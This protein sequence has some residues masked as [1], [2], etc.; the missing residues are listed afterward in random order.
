MDIQFPEIVLIVRKCTGKDGLNTTW[1]CPSALLK[2]ICCHG[3]KVGYL[4]YQ[5]TPNDH[6]SSAPLYGRM[7]DANPTYIFSESLII[8]D[9]DG[10]FTN[11]KKI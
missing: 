8:V 9:S 1:K 4:R 3:Y 6:H 11:V 10:L 5:C 7:V 2:I